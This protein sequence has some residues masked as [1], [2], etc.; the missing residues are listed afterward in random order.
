MVAER[1]KSRLAVYLVTIKDGKVLLLRRFNT[2]WMDGY[3]GMVSGHLEE[4]E[5]ATLCMVREAKEEAGLEIKPEDLKMIHVMHYH[6]DHDYVNFFFVAKKWKGEP[7]NTEP[8]KCNDLSW[9][10]LDNLPDNTLPY[11]KQALN[12]ME[13][14]EVYSEYGWDE[15]R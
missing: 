9:F 7:R 3:Y 6:S 12:D 15:R 1:H 8:E 10:P 14:G 4:G 13:N 5:S 11:L 2:G